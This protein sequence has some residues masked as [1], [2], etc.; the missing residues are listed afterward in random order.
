MCLPVCSVYSAGYSCVY[1]LVDCVYSAGYSC[2][3]M[4]VD[5]VYSAGYSCVRG[6]WPVCV[7]P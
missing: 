5:C 7:S 3:Y 1:M 6:P 4:L 2:V